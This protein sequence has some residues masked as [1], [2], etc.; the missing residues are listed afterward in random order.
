MFF[1]GD[2]NIQSKQFLP[3]AKSCNGRIVKKGVWVVE[4]GLRDVFT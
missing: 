3:A 1:V 4:M 2:N